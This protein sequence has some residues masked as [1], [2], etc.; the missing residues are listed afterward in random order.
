M[1]IHV[2]RILNKKYVVILTVRAASSQAKNVTHYPMVVLGGG[3]GGSSVAARA[4]R[5]LGMG[6]VA[7]VDPAK[8]R[9][10]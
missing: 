3:A 8:V 10:N 5:F 2:S 6:N 9:P 4:C 7:V 1:S